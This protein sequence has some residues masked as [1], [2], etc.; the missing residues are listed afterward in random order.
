MLKFKLGC[1]ISPLPP[2]HIPQV[3]STKA[4][5]FKTLNKFKIYQQ[6]RVEVSSLKKRRKRKREAMSVLCSRDTHFYCSKAGPA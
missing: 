5:P 1:Y 6:K 3:H 4:S 2:S